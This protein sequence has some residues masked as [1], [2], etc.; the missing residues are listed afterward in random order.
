[1]KIGI[2]TF[3]E[4]QDNYGQI[5]Q[6]FALKNYLENKGHDVFIIK[7]HR[8]IPV[9]TFI[10]RLTDFNLKDFIARRITSKKKVKK[11]GMPSRGFDQFKKKHLNYSRQSYFSLKDLVQ[12]PPVADVYISGSDQVWNNTFKVS[13]EAF[14][15]G[16]GDNKTIRLSYAASFGMKNLDKKTR[17][18][19]K[20]NIKRFNGIS[21]REESG[22]DI[23]NE[24]G[25]N[26]AVWVPDPTLL[27]NRYDWTSSLSIDVNSSAQNKIFVYVVGTGYIKDKQKIIDYAGSLPGK[28]VSHATANGSQSG[29]SFP[30]IEEWVKSISEA[31]F[32]ITNSFHGM[33]FCII[34]HK[35]FIV[36]PNGGKAADM[37]ER[38][39]SLLEKVGLKDHIMYEFKKSS[40]DSLLAKEIDWQKISIILEEWS[41]DASLFFREFLSKKESGAIS[42]YSLL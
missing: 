24:M 33:V 39:T 17:L 4:S 27:F 29:D 1:M 14:L 38:I 10:E 19:F 32:V 16:F 9:K 28:N 36:L 18:L 8:V 15:L 7:Y 23:C 25:Y 2:M 30:S 22:V 40:I 6:A 13:C 26:K 11:S 20:N 5:L 31:D 3:W 21:V 37:N 12:D 41:K 35:K 42:N 34:F